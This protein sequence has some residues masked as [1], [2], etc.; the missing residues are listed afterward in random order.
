MNIL[1]QFGI[2]P[3]DFATLEAV[4]SEYKYLALNFEHL[5]QRTSQFEEKY[6]DKNIGDYSGNFYLYDAFCTHARKCK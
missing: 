3:I 5:C 1:E 4:L 2:V 6:I